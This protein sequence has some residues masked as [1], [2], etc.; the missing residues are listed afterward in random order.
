MLNN[1][2]NLAYPERWDT[3][4]LVLPLQTESEDSTYNFQVICSD[5]PSVKAGKSLWPPSSKEPKIWLRWEPTPDNGFWIRPRKYDPLLRDR[6][7][8]IPPYEIIAS[9]DKRSI[10]RQTLIDACHFSAISNRMVWHNPAKGGANSPNSA[11]FQSIP[12]HWQDGSRQRFT[13]PCCH[14]QNKALQWT[15]AKK[16]HAHLLERGLYNHKYPILGLVVWGPI[17]EVAEYVWKVISNYDEAR[18]CNLVIQPSN[19]STCEDK[20]RIFVFPRNR[21]VPRYKVIEDLLL[22]DEIILL[23]NN[24]GGVWYEWPF[25]GVEMG[26]LTQVEWGPLFENMCMKPTKWGDTLLRLLQELS[27]KE[28]ETDWFDFVSIV[29]DVNSNI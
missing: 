4:W 28:T 2:L 27:L 13:F 15:S 24:R 20:I 5:L 17:H 1:I 8:L 19:V 23:N 26:L 21:V 25:A 14:F 12:V 9:N 11:H 6:F 16:I 10:T 7:N 3:V 18:A 29:E 22:E